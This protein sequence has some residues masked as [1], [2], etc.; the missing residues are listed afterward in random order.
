M[1]GKARKSNNKNDDNDDLPPVNK[2]GRSTKKNVVVGC[3]DRINKSV[4]AKVMIKNN[5]GKKLTGKQLLDIL[6]Q[7]I[8]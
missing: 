6:H 8:T 5:E 4:L 2:R 1:G 3:V 7:V